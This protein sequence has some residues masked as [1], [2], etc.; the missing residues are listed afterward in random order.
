[1]YALSVCALFNLRC[2]V[3]HI[4]YFVMV[5]LFSFQTYFDMNPILILG[6]DSAST[7]NQAY[8]FN[9]ESLDLCE[10]S[11]LPL[12]DKRSLQKT[13]VLFRIRGHVEFGFE[14]HDQQGIE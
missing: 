13:H 6:I 4:H 3:Y 1:M 12:D 9:L 5:K 10:A 11:C 7:T 2:P 8:W 14:H